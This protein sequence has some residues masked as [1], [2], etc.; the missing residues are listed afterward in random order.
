MDT[1]GRDDYRNLSWQMVAKGI[2]SPEG[3]AVDAAGN[4]FL[5]S[6]WTGRVLQVTP[7]GD[8]IEVVQTGGK[9]QAVALLP[10]G[11]LLLADA[12]N[13]ALCRI[14]RQGEMSVVAD[15]ANDRPLL[16]PNDLVVAE[17]GIVY[18]TDPGLE[19]QG[20]GQILRVDTLSGDATVLGEGY[21]FPNGITL[22]ADGAY[23]VVAESV[24]HRVVRFQLLDHGTR[25][26]DPEVFCQF[27]DHYPDG[28][29]F[30]ALGN[31][32]V[33]LHGNGSVHVFDPTGT[34]IAEVPTGGKG[35]T[36]CVFGGRNFQT[37]YVTEDD[38][39]ALLAA[40]WPVPGQRRFSRS[41]TDGVL[42]L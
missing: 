22:S 17:N 21:R 14:T 40:Q 1:S 27:D 7:A 4:V 23:L 25:L 38:Q 28:I 42:R 12:K 29:C 5:V 30:D 19:L 36:N 11:D 15:R 3:P 13:Y 9:P 41:F 16:G 39:Q 8:V 31:L 32:L 2:L 26:S 18:M 34:K 10:S 37:L 35:S 24:R 20:Y 6:R 33:T